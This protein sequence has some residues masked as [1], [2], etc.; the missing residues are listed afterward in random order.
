MD[1]CGKVLGA[2]LQLLVIDAPKKK[3]KLIY[4]LEE[5]LYCYHLVIRGVSKEMGFTT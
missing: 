5:L 2:V 3:S 1:R 4:I